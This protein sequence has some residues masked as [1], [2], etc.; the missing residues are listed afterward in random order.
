M[1][2]VYVKA[3]GHLSRAMFRVAEA[4]RA[5]APTHITVVDRVQDADVQVLHVIGSDALT[6]VS[7][8]PGYAVIQYCFSRLD[9]GLE[10][11]QRLWA[12]S[13]LTWSYYDLPVALGTRFYRSPLG[14]DGVFGSTT[15][16][17]T[18]PRDYVMTSGY[19]TGPGAEAIEE[20]AHAA[21]AVGLRT[22]HIGP[23]PVGLTRPLPSSWTNRFN[24]S[25]AQLAELYAGARWVSGLRHVE[26]FELPA[27]EG[28]LCGTRPVLFDREDMRA[29]YTSHGEF[30]A[31]P[32][33]RA[34]IQTQLEA[35]FARV[36]GSVTQEEHALLCEQFNWSRIATEFWKRMTA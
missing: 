5:Y 6:Y 2:K 24:I 36:P 18:Q 30:I 17:A 3:P 20:V 21:H 28:L 1:L 12:R 32:H 19:V 31:E 16:S 33:D 8:A 7:R 4:L 22:V 10:N 26:G 15:R 13:S 11:W 23:V 25:D 35:V 29:W 34:E 9:G 27:A 14:V